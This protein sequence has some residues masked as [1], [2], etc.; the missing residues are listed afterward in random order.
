MRVI[1]EVFHKE[2]FIKRLLKESPVSLLWNL[3]L[4]GV[5]SSLWFPIKYEKLCI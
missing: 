2:T 4:T 5:Y 3:F 1:V